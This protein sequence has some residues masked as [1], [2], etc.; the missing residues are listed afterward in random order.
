MRSEYCLAGALSNGFHVSFQ[1]IQTVGIENQRRTIVS[2]QVQ[3]QPLDSGCPGS[4]AAGHQRI[5]R[6][7]EMAD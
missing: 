5:S 2:Q 1:G 6:V 4:T 7:E 3:Y